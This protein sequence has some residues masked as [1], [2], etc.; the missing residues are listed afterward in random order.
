MPIF[1]HGLVSGQS[2]RR[3]IELLLLLYPAWWVLLAPPTGVQLV[4]VHAVPTWQLLLALLAALLAAAGAFFSWRAYRVSGEVFLRRLTV[5]FV[6]AATADCLQLGEFLNP[7]HDGHI[8]LLFALLGRFQLAAGLCLALRSLYQPAE[9]PRPFG[10]GGFWRA[11]ASWIV[12]SSLVMLAVASAPLAVA[13]GVGLFINLL[14]LVC[15]AWAI[16]MGLRRR[17]DTPAMNA[18]LAS[19]LLLAQATL[20]MTWADTYGYF[21]G[22]SLVVCISAYLVLGHGLVSEFLVMRAVTGGFSVDRVIR[23]LVEQKTQAEARLAELEKWSGRG[24]PSE[25]EI[26]GTND[27]ERLRRRMAAELERS[28]ATGAPLLLLGVAIARWDALFVHH[29]GDRL[30]ALRAAVADR[31]QHFQGTLDVIAGDGQGRFFVLCPEARPDEL[32]ERFARI[33]RA[34]TGQPFHLGSF[35]LYLDCREAAVVAGRDGLLADELIAICNRRLDLALLATAR[36]YI[37]VGNSREK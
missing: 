21:W 25:A 32:E 26:A 10:A 28:R 29:G 18:L 34:L 37:A 13:R 33:H 24:A 7:D 6:A 12:W 2:F 31:L 19:L 1:L 11:T 16:A 14:T 27:V 36:E 20:I 22:F 23:H 4:R 17:Q 9:T 5:A 3:F 30:V 15:T 35:A 8:A